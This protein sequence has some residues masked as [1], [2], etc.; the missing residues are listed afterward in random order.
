MYNSSMI[1]TIQHYLLAHAINCVL[2][3]RSVLKQKDT[4]EVVMLD[5]HKSHFFMY[6]DW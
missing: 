6:N 4:V 2:Q 3:L 1:Y 5:V